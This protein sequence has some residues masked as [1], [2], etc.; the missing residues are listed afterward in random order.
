M[1]EPGFHVGVRVVL[2]HGLPFD[3]RMWEGERELVPG[4][5]IAPALYRLGESLE[6]WAQGVLALVGEEPIVVVGCSAGGSC[7]LEVAAAA[8]E[9]VLGIVLV[10]AKAGVRADPGMR[11]EAVRMLRRHGMEA[12]WKTYWRPLFGRN[13]P[14]GVLA[15]AR[16]MAL[17]QEVE[18]IVR[19]VR[20]FHDRRDLTDFALTWPR[21]LVV[22][23]GDQDRT[24]L[25]GTA[26][27]ITAAPNRRFH[28]V[29]DCG[30]YVN[31]ERPT[32]LRTLVADAIQ[33]FGDQRR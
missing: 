6:E 16:E 24:P 11:D 31:L 1:G 26:A 12:A 32:E 20:A 30:H 21:P 5:T 13:T 14:E 3:G 4:G 25:P 15:S 2:L 17:G 28:L 27:R 18:D 33:R 9:Q 23:S 7:A 10:G 19:G 8:P 22:I 29:E